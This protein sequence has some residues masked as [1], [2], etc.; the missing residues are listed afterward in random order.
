MVKM[1]RD[2]MTNALTNKLM[3]PAMSVEETTERKTMKNVLINSRRDDVQVG[4]ANL[5]TITSEMKGTRSLAES[6]SEK[7][8]N[9]EFS[10]P[11]LFCRKFTWSHDHSNK[12]L[13][14]AALATEFAKPLPSPPKALLENPEIQSTLRYL[15]KYIK[16]ETPFNID[17]FESL[18]IDHPN[19]PFVKS[20]M[21]V[22]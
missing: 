3:D 1:S 16:V 5:P 12:T 18:L 21:K 20:V 14:P 9:T 8:K 4:Q 13:L 11:P 6:T 17:C 7:R 22:L 2:M 15:D 10:E 19:Q